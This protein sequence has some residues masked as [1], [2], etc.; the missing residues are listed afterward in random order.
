MS[1][2]LPSFEFP[3]C[4]R[5]DRLVDRMIIERNH[6]TG[7]FWITVFCHDKRQRLIVTAK[8]IDEHGGNP[9]VKISTAFTPM[10]GDSDG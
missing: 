10:K 2:K 5:C 1:S 9:V 7:S 4:A 6:D 8:E 3:R